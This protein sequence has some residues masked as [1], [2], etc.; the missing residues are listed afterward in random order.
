MQGFSAA[1]NHCGTSGTGVDDET[2]RVTVDGP[3]GVRNPPAAKGCQ[4]LLMADPREGVMLPL[5][6]A[7]SIWPTGSQ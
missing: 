2:L 6:V 5:S 4:E 1:W 7:T 3:R